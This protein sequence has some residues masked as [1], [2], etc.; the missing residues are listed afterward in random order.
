VHEYISQGSVTE[1]IGGA[2]LADYRRTTA[3]AAAA[4]ARL[5][6]ARRGLVVTVVG[7]YYGV[8]AADAKLA[9]ARR[10]LDALNY[11]YGIDAP[12]FAVHAPDGSRNLGYSGSITFDIPVW[13]WFTTH[14]KVHESVARGQQAR[15]E[16]TATQRQLIAS[17]RETYQEAQVSLDQLHLLD[18][19]V[20]SARESLRLTNLSYASGEG[21]VL[22]I[23]DSENTLVQ[24]ESSRAEGAARYFNAL[25]TLQTFTGSMPR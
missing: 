20:K 24:S 10:A 22:E 19:S 12:Q 2:S 1:T 21:N 23:V 18:T 13:D 14:S 9:V 11:N 4:R 5:E 8:L 3:E 25:A 17:L 6:V 7:N 15:I 16:L